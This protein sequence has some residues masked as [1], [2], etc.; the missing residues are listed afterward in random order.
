MDN[1]RQQIVDSIKKSS[2]ILVAVS[3]DPSVDEL[4]AA[5]GLSIILNNL[6]KRATAIFSGAIPPAITFLEP[7]KTFENSA[8]SLRDFIVALHKEKADHLRYKVEGDV[9][10][11]FITPYKTTLTKDDLE[12]SLGDYNIDMVL[13]LGVRD[14]GHL[15]KALEAHGKILHDAT[16]VTITSGNDESSLGSIDWHDG[17]ASSLSEM[18]VSLAD[19]LKGEGPIF[20]EQI[21]TALLTGIVS[22]TS[23]FSNDHTTS[24]SMTM[25]AQLMA[26]G[27]NQQLIAAKLEEAHDIGPESS[28]VSDEKAADM[29]PTEKSNEL[30]ID[31]SGSGNKA[32]NEEVP[33][34][35]TE[36]K[37]ATE[38]PEEPKTDDEEQAQHELEKQL[39]GLTTTATGTL[40]DIEN[41]LK[42]VADQ[43]K[44]NGGILPPIVDVTKPEVSLEQP[45]VQPAPVEPELEKSVENTPP[46]VEPPVA[47]LPPIVE[48]PVV[49][50]PAVEEPT[51][52]ISKFATSSSLV[53][54]PLGSFEAPG[55]SEPPRVDPFANPIAS[56]DSSSMESG[57]NNFGIPDVLS[58]HAPVLEPLTSPQPELQTQP[59]PESAPTLAPP[60]IP[61]LPPL[62]PLPADM[63]LPP[64]PPPPPPPPTFG[65]AP[66]NMPSG[67]V[68]GD[69]FGD[70][71]GADA[72]PPAPTTP[73]E[74]GQFKIPGQ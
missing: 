3:S 8:D 2:N 54:P 21:A 55:D 30:S 7:D 41:E 13:A 37:P 6:D 71:A 40:A 28:A 50:E 45:P 57:V 70:G 24:R 19:S 66:A 64:L 47:T 16:V 73:P 49:A 62:P 36:E 23:R 48:P 65:Q 22:A 35:N 72:T 44:P 31:R 4:S 26:S 56:P 60:A 42:E 32:S 38:K 61:E 39:A 25:A 9:V 68:S 52:Q 63:S 46:V 11:I 27:A 20:D 1:A 69:V 53:M 17:M 33:A 34:D 29:I 18:V 74:P 51:P 59:A 5:L 10:K 67:A 15:D 14:Q 58:A 43:S 12:F